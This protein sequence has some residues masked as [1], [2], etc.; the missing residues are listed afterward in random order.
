[1]KKTVFLSSLFALALLMCLFAGVA[2]AEPEYD[3]EQTIYLW[4]GG[5]LYDEVFD[6]TLPPEGAEVDSEGSEVIW[7][8]LPPGVILEPE[9]HFKTVTGKRLYYGSDD[10][11]G[12]F[13]GPTAS[14][15]FTA[16]VRIAY[17]KYGMKAGGELY[18]IPVG[19]TVHKATFIVDD[20]LTHYNASKVIYLKQGKTYLSDPGSY[21]GAPKDYDITFPY[22]EEVYGPDGEQKIGVTKRFIGPYEDDYPNF[23]PGLRFL[24]EW[25]PGGK[26]GPPDPTRGYKGTPEVNCTYD[27]FYRISPYELPSYTYKVTFIVGSGEGEPYDLWIDGTQVSSA[28]RGDIL[29]NGAFSYDDVTRTLR[30]KKS[31]EQSTPGMALIKSEIND[32]NIVAENDVTLFSKSTAMAL[33]YNTV[34]SGGGKLRVITSAETAIS[35]KSYTDITIDNLDLTAEAAG[36]AIYCEGNNASLTIKGENGALLARGQKRA[37]SGFSKGI[38]LQ[39]GIELMAPKEGYID[40]GK[41]LMDSGELSTNAAIRR[42]KSFPLKIDGNTVTEK[43]M[44]DPSGDGAFSFDGDKTLHIKGSHTSDLTIIQNSLPGLVIAVD[45]DSELAMSEYGMGF[46]IV[47]LADATI[48]GPGKLTLKGMDY[49]SAIESPYAD[50]V[51]IKDIDLEVIGG[52]QGIKGSGSIYPGRLTVDHSRVHVTI[53]NTWNTAVSGFNGGIELVG[54]KIKSPEDGKIDAGQIVKA[55]GTFTDEILIT[56]DIWITITGASDGA[57]DITITDLPG[58]GEALTLTCAAYD[59]D[60]KMVGTTIFTFIDDGSNIHKH[61]DAVSGAVSYKVLL[62]DENYCPVVPNSEYIP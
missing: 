54:C 15:T 52:N 13:S 30:I 5:T 1:M 22:P 43:N 55:D 8:K 4:K 38:T 10:S 31:Y 48:T 20:K 36:N 34:F 44:D 40:S 19:S 6:G 21:A 7:G 9:N 23:L 47:L 29:G 26:E 49:N 12:V 2:Y 62:L 53:N 60:G 14:G 33:S 37:V 61:F 16:Y 3:T 42:I 56:P 11:N 27:I 25:R 24:N 17:I 59:A 50:A 32:L 51:T 39:E 45:S 46:P 57:M 28:N 41:V 58:S 35:V 18:K